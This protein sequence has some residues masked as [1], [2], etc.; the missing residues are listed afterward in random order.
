[1]SPKTYVR[2]LQGGII[3]S[4]LVVLFVFKELLFPYITSKQLPFNIIMEFLL[5]IWV[6]FLMRYP[7]YRPKKNMISYGLIAYFL[8]ILASCAVSV[9][10]N[11]SFWGDAE[12]MLGFFHLA[13]FLIFYF[14]I[15]TVFRSWKDWHYLFLASITTATV[16]SLSGL[17]GSQEYGTIGNTA[18]VSGYLIFNL[19]FIILL[20]FRA[21]NKSARWLYL[22]PFLIMIIEFWKMKTSGAIIGLGVS[23]LLLFLLL[24]LSHINK[25]VRRGSLIA[26]L[27][28]IAILVFIFSQSQAAWFQNSF[29]RNLTTQKATFQ[30]RLISW[31]AAAHDFK[32]HPIFGNGFGNYA[33]TFDKYFDS[34]FYDYATTDTYFDRAHNNLI[35]ITSTTGVVGLLTY[36]SIF[37]AALYYLWR[38][39][40]QNGGRTGGQDAGGLNNL[41]IVIIVALLSAYFIQ[42]LAIFD[43]FSTFLGL[44]AILG[45]V[46]WLNFRRHY[47]IVPDEPENALLTIKKDKTEALVLIG[48]LIAAYIFANHYNFKTLKMFKGTIDAYIEVASGRLVEGVQKYSEVLEGAPMERDSRVTLINLVASNPNLL[49]SINSQAAE[50]IL[51]YTIDLARRNVA[52]NPYDS[53]MQMQLANVLDTAARYYYNDLEKLNRY[54]GEAMQSIEYSIEATPNRATVYFVKSQMQLSRGETEEAIATL[55]EGIAL[56]PNYYEGHCRL[57]QLFFITAQDGV[58]DARIDNALQSCL[59]T[60]RSSRSISDNLLKLAANYYSEKKEYRQAAEFS[61]YLAEI[62]AP[63]AE[64]WNNV[65]RLYFVI[66]DKEK[67]ESS[68]IKAVDLNPELLEPWLE[69]KAYVEANRKEFE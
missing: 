39:F 67:A 60:G 30:T 49:S 43:S 55:E 33:T 32:N 4:L 25:K 6:V 34:K 2:I 46:Y 52:Y 8:A 35:E 23:F 54:S 38:E 61:E 50:E 41:E 7:E 56:N 57:A 37:I 1:M 68:F 27:A 36:L 64:I 29:L 28:S 44:M 48:L 59:S 12:R 53:M 16:V 22:I 21:N 20:F 63:D 5:V 69:F 51:E 11:L 45:F 65:A 17:L 26:F 40:K 3:A 9:D 42:N 15:I 24:G 13:H 31:Q 58:Y 14:I 66:G 47:Q 62:A 19:Y 10:F 18:Y